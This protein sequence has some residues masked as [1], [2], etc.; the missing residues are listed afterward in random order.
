MGGQAIEAKRINTFLLPPE[1]ICIIEDEKHPLYDARVNLPL[2]EGTVLSIMAFG[3][4]E[5]ILAFK[6]G[7]KC[8]VI[9]GIQRVRNAREANKRLAK[10]GKELVLVRTILEKAPEADLFG[11]KLLANEN[12]QDDTPIAKAEKMQRYI[13][14]GRTEEQ[15]AVVAG[16]K[17]SGVKAHLALL[18]LAKPVQNAV[19][20][21]ELSV[22]AAAHLSGLDREQ[23]IEAL[24]GTAKPA[25]GKKTTVKAAKK[26]V[27]KA[28]AKP[29]EEV[30]DGPPGR[31]EIR[32]LVMSEL[33]ES[34]DALDALLWVLLGDRKGKIAAALKNLEAAKENNS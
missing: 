6:D 24:N 12:R 22:T 19:I 8:V 16:L 2:D 26:A 11:I 27:K 13:A 34:E 17:V 9:D 32:K 20:A 25:P 15:A 21:G 3:V 18:D 30:E 5:P 4:K 33:L 10:E 23:Q 7:D 28:K 14:M 31:L 1:D 29:G